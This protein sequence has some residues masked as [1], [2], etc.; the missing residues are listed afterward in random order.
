MKFGKVV[1]ESKLNEYNAEL[2]KDFAKTRAEVSKLSDAELLARQKA[3]M[4]PNPNPSV[5]TVFRAEFQ[6]VDTVHTDTTDKDK[7]VLSKSEIV[8][9]ILYAK[10]ERRIK[11]VLQDF[12]FYLSLQNRSFKAFKIPSHD[13]IIKYNGEE[14]VAIVSADDG[15]VDDTAS[16]KITKF[17]N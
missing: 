6:G 17:L 8:N 16:A 5:G 11:T 4:T 14:Y 3:R 13:L 12:V 15:T 9:Q 2:A 10:N 7:L 1:N